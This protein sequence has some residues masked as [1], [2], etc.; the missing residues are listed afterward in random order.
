MASTSGVLTNYT[1]PQYDGMLFMVGESRTPF[2][3]MAGGLNNPRN[4][5]IVVAKEFSL[6][7][8]QSLD[9]AS[10]PAITETQAY[11]G[12]TSTFYTRTRDE[13]TTQIF[14]EHIKVGYGALADARY[15]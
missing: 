13:Q 12:L 10:Q 15:V 9:A 2:I 3:N 7:Q 11:T 4:G 5:R 1:C 6:G 14:Q 8:T